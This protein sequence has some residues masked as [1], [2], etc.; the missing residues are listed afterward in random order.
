MMSFEDALD[1]YDRYAS[2]TGKTAR[3]GKH[4]AADGHGTPSPDGKKKKRG[5]S[6]KK[7]RH[8]YTVANIDADTMREVKRVTDEEERRQR[9]SSEN[10]K[11]QQLAREYSQRI[12]ERSK[13]MTR[14]STVVEEP[15]PAMLYP[16]KPVWL[17]D[18]QDR[19]QQLSVSMG[20]H[21]SLENLLNC[22]TDDDTSSTSTSSTS[23]SI[24]DDVS[25]KATAEGGA[26][27]TKVKRS[28]T[29]SSDIKHGLLFDGAEFRE[30]VG[31]EDRQKKQRF[32]GWVK[33][34]AAKFSK[35]EGTTL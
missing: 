7:K 8:G 22:R 12:R 5:K 23:V 25:G 32:R 21:N 16:A 20:H 2:E 3:S 26:H 10:S 33:S 30:H 1:T 11:V 19:R 24:G 34:L 27:K 15:K 17:T 18:L 31:E 29:M 35:K 13:G 28:H 14:Y 4:E 6:K 9:K